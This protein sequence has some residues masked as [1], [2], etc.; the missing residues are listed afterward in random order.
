MSAPLISIS[1]ET[2]LQTA[3]ELMTSKKIRKLPVIEDDEVIGIIVASE[4]GLVENS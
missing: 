2:D 4:I 3:A 1:P